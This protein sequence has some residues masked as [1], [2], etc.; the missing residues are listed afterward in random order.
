MLRLCWLELRLPLLLP[1][2]VLAVPFS[3]R[4]VRPVAPSLVSPLASQ[5]AALL[6]EAAPG[7]HELLAAAP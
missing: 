7:G 6:L 5:L 1:P 3:L 4:L 2:V